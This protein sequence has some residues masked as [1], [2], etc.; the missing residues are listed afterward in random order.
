MYNRF[1]KGLQPKQ[2]MLESLLEIKK[3]RSMLEADVHKLEKVKSW[4][5]KRESLTPSE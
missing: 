2:S 5:S 3:Q 1:D 4:I